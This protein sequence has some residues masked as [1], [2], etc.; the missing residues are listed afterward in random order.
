MSCTVSDMAAPRAGSLAAEIKQTRPFTSPAAE[1]TI[2]LLKTAD[3]VRRHFTRVVQQEG[4]TLQQY[5]VLRI[6]RGAKGTPLCVL[7]IQERLI[8]ETPGVS[9]LLDRL[10]AKRL[11]RRER[12]VEDRRLLECFITDEGLKLL[13]RLDRAVERADTALAGHL[14]PRQLATLI[15]LLALVRNAET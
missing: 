6:L 7:E 11:V 14:S 10:V 2:A 4:V 9:R 3:K 8:E 13:A 5:N 12:A 1:A 15:E